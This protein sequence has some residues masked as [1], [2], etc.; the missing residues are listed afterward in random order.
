VTHNPGLR[1]GLS[2]E[3]LSD[4]FHSD[5]IWYSHQY[6]FRAEQ[7]CLAGSSEATVPCLNSFAPAVGHASR[8]R[9]VRDFPRHPASR[10][11]SIIAAVC[12]RMHHNEISSL[13]HGVDLTLD[14]PTWDQQVLADLRDLILSETPQWVADIQSAADDGDIE[15]LRTVL[16]ALKGAMSIF[17]LDSVCRSAFEIERLIGR[18]DAESLNSEID[19]LNAICGRTLRELRCSQ[20]WASQSAIVG[21]ELQLQY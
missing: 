9:Q 4:A 15:R 12:F 2:S 20:E 7:N 21:A 16:E 3:R 6:N 8:R 17:G 19:K 1:P 14:E 10:G 11:D 13:C 18:H 5:S